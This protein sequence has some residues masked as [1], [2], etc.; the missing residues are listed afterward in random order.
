MFATHTHTH[1]RIHTP[2][3]HKHYIC[4]RISHGTS[5]TPTPTPTLSHPFY[6]HIYIPPSQ[7]TPTH[8]GQVVLM[9]V[10]TISP[11]PAV[12]F[13]GQSVEFNCTHNG[14]VD[15][16][17]TWLR[18]GESLSGVTTESFLMGGSVVLE[19][20]PRSWNGSRI[21]CQISPT[22]S[23]FTELIV[24]CEFPVLSVF[25]DVIN[26]RC[27]FLRVFCQLSFTQVS[28]NMLPLQHNAQSPSVQ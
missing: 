28:F 12:I 19:A 11:S 13:Q 25:S 27:L 20:I 15:A 24:L 14:N 7:H 21:T 3:M 1:A 2:H 26:N 6:T 8:A 9:P 16:N 10:V 5:H 23:A 4:T 17:I 18:N 22:A